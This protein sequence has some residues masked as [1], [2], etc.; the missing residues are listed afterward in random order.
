M[1]DETRSHAAVEQIARI[2]Q[3][4]IELYK[5]RKAAVQAARVNEEMGLVDSIIAKVESLKTQVELLGDS[6]DDTEAYEHLLRLKSAIEDFNRFEEDYKNENIWHRYYRIVY[7]TT[8]YHTRVSKR[9]RGRKR[10]STLEPKRPPAPQESVVKLAF[11]QSPTY[12]KPGIIKLLYPNNQDVYIEF[13]PR[14]RV[15]WA[16]LEKLASQNPANQPY[17]YNEIAK[18]LGLG[19]VTV[20]QACR[21]LTEKL[22]GVFIEIVEE[23]NAWY[24]LNILQ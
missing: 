8:R 14:A 2:V 17:T 18:L 5:Q 16:V 7:Y 24:V 21:A 22:P 6:Q 19:S 1:E 23:E 3:E 11:V 9:G 12:D 15:Q 4:C 10:R 20:Y 13:I